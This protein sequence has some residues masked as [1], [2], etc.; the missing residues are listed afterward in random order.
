MPPGFLRQTGLYVAAEKAHE[1]ANLLLV[2]PVFERGHAVAA[3][4]NLFGKLRV[5]VRQSMPFEQARN[6]QTLVLDLDHAALALLL[7]TSGANI[8]VGCFRFC[9]F[10]GRSCRSRFRSCGGS[11]L[12]ARCIDCLIRAG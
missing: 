6:F 12:C 9:Q 2:E 3:V 10:I 4:R 8:R 5:C 11:G 7:M 1:I